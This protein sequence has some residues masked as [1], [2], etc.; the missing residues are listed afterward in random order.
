MSAD[1]SIVVVSAPYDDDKDTDSGFAYIFA[2]VVDESYLQTHK[3]VATDGA[4]N[5]QFGRSVAVS[6]TSVVVGAHG[7]L[8]KGAAYV[9]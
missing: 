2:K 8:G 3:L 1:G 4:A 6:N 9:Y 5:D 7:H